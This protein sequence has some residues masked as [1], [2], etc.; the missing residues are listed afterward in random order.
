[1]TL[2]PCGKE[3]DKSRARTP[4]HRRQRRGS[5]PQSD[6]PPRIPGS[7]P[8]RARR[9]G[10]NTSRRFAV[11]R[12][13][14]GG[15]DERAILSKR[16]KSPIL[17]G[18]LLGKESLCLRV[19]CSLPLQKVFCLLFFRKVRRLLGEGASLNTLSLFPA[20]SKSLLLPFLQKRKGFSFS[21][22]ISRG[23]S[24]R[25]PRSRGR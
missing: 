23:Y 7:S 18:R 17:T 5:F 2:F 14:S 10:R 20:P 13:R 25:R 11:R 1:M 4:F 9:R 21:G 24:V 3:R 15:G 16:R 6:N 22:N 8:R 12:L 19:V